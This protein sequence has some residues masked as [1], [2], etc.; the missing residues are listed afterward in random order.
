MND[1]VHSGFQEWRK[2]GFGDLRISGFG[3]FSR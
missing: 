3:R 1:L 2:S